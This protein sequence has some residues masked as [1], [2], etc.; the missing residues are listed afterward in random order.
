VVVEIL[1]RGPPDRRVVGVAKSEGG[2]T[3]ARI[4]VAGRAALGRGPERP[5]G[6]S[7]AP[8]LAREGASHA[9]RPLAH[10]SGA[11]TDRLPRREPPVRRPRPRVRDRSS[12]DRRAPRRV[13]D[14]RPRS[15]T[16]TGD[17]SP[18]RR[19]R[20]AP[21]ASGASIGEIDLLIHRVGRDR[22]DGAAPD[23]ME[24]EEQDRQSQQAGERED[25]RHRDGTGDPP[26]TGP[27]IA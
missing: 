27:A 17:A 3:M 20:R 21:S 10:R 16:H 1:S 25:P 4:R 23:R 15:Q 2:G 26:T 12:L 5:R 8:Y 13:R 11:R 19:R 24:V 22:A 18:S 9:W 7:E 14:P 6:R